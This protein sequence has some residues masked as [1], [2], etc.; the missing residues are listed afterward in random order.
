MPNCTT[1]E[2]RPPK[3]RRKSPQG[4]IRWRTLRVAPEH[5]CTPYDR[6]DYW[7]S[8]SV[9][10]RI[11]AGLGGVYGPYTGRWFRSKYDTD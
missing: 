6:D 7:Y 10:D 11:I 9:V 5:R 1:R 3:G 2:A 8:Q 4:A